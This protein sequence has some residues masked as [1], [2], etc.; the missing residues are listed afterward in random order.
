MF[1]WLFRK[2]TK[3][4][5]ATP[6]RITGA[7]EKHP[8]QNF[9]YPPVANGIPRF[10]V[11]EIVEAHGDLIRR[12]RNLSEHKNVFD[13]RYR[14]VI[15]RYANYVHLLPAS[16]SH[17]HRGAGGLLSHGLETGKFVLQQ[18]Y[19]RLHGMQLSPQKRK[20]ARERWLF[21]SFVS[22]LTH[23]IGKVADMRVY[24]V[25]GQTWE[26]FSQPLSAWHQA[27]PPQD[28][29]VFVSWRREG[30]DHRQ[31][32]LLLLHRIL[33]TED[34]AY[35]QEI[36][37]MFLRVSQAILGTKGPRNDND[38][39][40]MVEE[41]DRQSVSK[42]LQ[43]SNVLADLGPETRQPLVRHFVMAMK[44]LV[45]EGWWRANELGSVLW[46]MGNDQ[47]CYLVW[48][49]M[50]VDVVNLLQ[51]D[52]TPGIPANPEAL[53][54]ILHEHC[55]LMLAPNGNRFWRV[56]PSMVEAGGEGLIALRLKEP[57]YI[58][59]L[60]PP[61]A[62]GEVRGEGE[63]TLISR[64][65]PKAPPD[66]PVDRSQE[67]ESGVTQTPPSSPGVLVEPEPLQGLQS[68][69]EFKRYFGGGGLGG[70]A[71]LK[72]ALEVS[73]GVRRE[74]VDYKTGPQL[75]LAWG[76][77][78]FTAEESLSEVIESLAQ[79]GWLVLNGN[80]RVHKEPQ[81]GRCLKLGEMAT[82]LFLRLVG[83]LPGG[84]QDAPSSSVPL[85]GDS[86]VQHKGTYSQ[87]AEVP[88][89]PQITLGADEPGWVR[90]VTALIN[91]HGP[92]DYNQVREM[93]AERIGR[94]QDIFMLL[95]RYFE[96][97]D[98]DGELVV[99]GRKT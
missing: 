52:G 97:A 47:G 30:L 96:F 81:F 84:D 75:L 19:D 9:A 22:G 87:G 24:S 63:K 11:S 60:V 23:D 5:A 82:A 28:D 8:V 93:A 48:P 64:I 45:T 53:A 91:L 38:I 99:L 49:E 37:S 41:G 59:D 12:L 17:H 29:R 65:E 73:V 78:K 70:Q 42:D 98:D 20:D 39:T 56:R 67:S 79:A 80:R 50:A 14:P 26:P 71:L 68:L 6:E 10:P 4:Q 58:L 69:E 32:G 57:R 21:A 76:E 72:L 25:S 31:T 2:R 15:A 55:L 66:L 35:L 44:R 74:G 90:E 13:E 92:V 89:E 86:F 54:D 16:E 18:S 94:R 27:L 62:S 43:N 88:P 83:L 33:L 61:S 51:N 77:R 40:K 46:V 34:I 3:A 1:G 7:T 85:G 36:E 95:S